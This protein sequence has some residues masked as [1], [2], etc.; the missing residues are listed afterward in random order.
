MIQR[1]GKVSLCLLY[2]MALTL[3]ELL[4]IIAPRAEFRHLIL[5]R[6]PQPLHNFPSFPRATSYLRSLKEGQARYIM[7]IT[8]NRAHYGLEVLSTPTPTATC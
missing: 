4:S 2:D 3:E 1:L 5:L 6:S 8:V 7:L